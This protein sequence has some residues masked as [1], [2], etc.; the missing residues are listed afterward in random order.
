MTKMTPLL[1][2]NEQFAATYTPGP[3]SPP[4]AQV[5]IATGRVTTVLDARHPQLAGNH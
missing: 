2:R 1:E 4:A 5:V 3:L